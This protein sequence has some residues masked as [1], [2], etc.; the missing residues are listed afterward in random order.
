[1]SFSAGRCEWRSTATQKE[2]YGVPAGRIRLSPF[3]SSSNSILHSQTV[4]NPRQGIDT[5]QIWKCHLVLL[6]DSLILMTV[7]QKKGLSF[8]SARDERLTIRKMIP[9][10]DIVSCDPEV[11]AEWVQLE[12]SSAGGFLVRTG[13]DLYRI[14]VPEGASAV[15]EWRSAILQALPSGTNAEHEKLEIVK[16]FLAPSAEK[17]KELLS[18]DIAQIPNTIGGK[19]VV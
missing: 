8:G 5:L 15:D 6:N 4:L 17:A 1:M 18:S 10:A 13:L 9:I 7:E 16:N 19:S 2:R 12:T 11:N 3:L 14:V